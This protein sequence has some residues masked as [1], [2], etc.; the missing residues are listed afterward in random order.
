M[1]AGS[2]ANLAKV[3]GIHLLLPWV[4]RRVF[5]ATLRPKLVKALEGKRALL[6]EE[7]SALREKQASRVCTL[8]EN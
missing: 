7:G 2:D 4:N 1:T 3:P 5:F 8:G 6:S